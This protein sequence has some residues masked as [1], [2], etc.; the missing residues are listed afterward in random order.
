MIFDSEGSVENQGQSNTSQ[1][2]LP[3]LKDDKIHV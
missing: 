3:M 1:V 2:T